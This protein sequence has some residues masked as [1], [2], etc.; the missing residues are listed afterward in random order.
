MSASQIFRC[1]SHRALRLGARFPTRA[2]RGVIPV[3]FSIVSEFEPAQ[4]A[5]V[6]RVRSR[7]S[8]KQREVRHDL[9]RMIDSQAPDHATL[10][11]GLRFDPSGTILR[12]GERGGHSLAFYFWALS[13]S[14]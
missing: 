3:A 2:R 11:R 1:R 4:T 7:M 9:L 13:Q 5:R 8:H 10:P 6:A 14:I 12:A